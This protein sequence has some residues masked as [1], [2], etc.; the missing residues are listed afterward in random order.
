MNEQSDKPWEEILLL[1]NRALLLE[2]DEENEALLRFVL[3]QA[4]QEAEQLAKQI[5]VS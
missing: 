4:K 1:I 2:K 5:M 3:N